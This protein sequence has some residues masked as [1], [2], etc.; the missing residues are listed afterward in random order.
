MCYPNPIP[1][2]DNATMLQTKPTLSRADYLQLDAQS[3]EKHEFL[4]GQVYAMAGGTFH[5]ARVSGNIFA[6]L[7][8]ALRGK[9]CQPMN[10][11]M[12]VHT[13]S[14]LDTYPDVS[15]FCGEP[16]LTDNQRTLLNPLIIIEVLSPSTRDYDRVGKFTHY[17]SIAGLQDYLLVDPETVLVEHFHRLK[18]DEWL[19]RVYSSLEDSLTL[20]SIGVTVNIR[21]FYEG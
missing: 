14:G 15:V 8:Q 2:L 6:I 3:D 12:R 4:D 19:L 17:R 7:R 1:P 5:H 9:P 16:E 18:R 13:P 21:A 11:D 20:D 10:S